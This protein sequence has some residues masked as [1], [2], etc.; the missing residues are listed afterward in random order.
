MQITNAISIQSDVQVFF[1][2]GKNPY[3]GLF[4]SNIPGDLLRSFDTCF[5]TDEYSGCEVAA[6]ADE[7]TVSGNGLANTFGVLEDILSFRSLVQH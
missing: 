2:K 7:I 4:V 1:D 3:Y 6:K 5:A